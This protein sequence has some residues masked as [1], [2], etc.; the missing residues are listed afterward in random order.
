[1][2][3]KNITLKTLI[4]LKKDCYARANKRVAE[5]TT[6][7]GDLGQLAQKIGAVHRQADTDAR[8]LA[9]VIRLVHYRA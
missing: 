7:G 5:L 9:W 3:N 6:A 4:N 8:R 2:K 1:M